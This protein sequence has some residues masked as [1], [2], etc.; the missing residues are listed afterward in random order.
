MLHVKLFSGFIF[1]CFMS[2]NLGSTAFAGKGQIVH[3]EGV[4]LSVFVSAEWA[5]RFQR[6]L[7]YQAGRGPGSSAGCSLLAPGP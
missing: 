1:P 7:I 4:G 2:S 5:R 3:T 6:N